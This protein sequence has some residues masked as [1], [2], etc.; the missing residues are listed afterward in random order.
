MFY[1]E[2]SLDCT[3]YEGLT[4]ANLCCFYFDDT[5]HGSHNDDDAVEKCV[6]RNKFNEPSALN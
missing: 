1:R 6:S 4:E 2:T 3:T 5:D